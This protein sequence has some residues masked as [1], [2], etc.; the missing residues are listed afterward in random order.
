M[1]QGWNV[2]FLAD[3]ILMKVNR[4]YPLAY[5]KAQT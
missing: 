1:T 2:K 5:S 3:L 4:V